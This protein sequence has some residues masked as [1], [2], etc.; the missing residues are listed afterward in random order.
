MGV[1]VGSQYTLDFYASFKFLFIR[2]MRSFISNFKSTSTVF[3][4]F[5]YSQDTMNKWKRYSLNNRCSDSYPIQNGSQQ[6]DALS[7][8]LE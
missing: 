2:R 7:P 3:F 8:L 4:N 5:K 1:R 6:G